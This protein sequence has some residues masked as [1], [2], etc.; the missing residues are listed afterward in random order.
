MSDAAM[1]M[2][3]LSMFYGY[4][5]ENT[6]CSC[7]HEIAPR[8]TQGEASR[9][10]STCTVRMTLQIVFSTSQLLTEEHWYRLLP[11]R[12]TFRSLGRIT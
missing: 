12:F 4:V 10:R 2:P 3:R 11:A 9:A 6:W 5:Q 1:Q 7:S 8:G